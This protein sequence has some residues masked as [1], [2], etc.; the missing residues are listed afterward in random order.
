MQSPGA[1]QQA[2]SYR[3]VYRIPGGLLNDCNYTVTVILTVNTTDKRIV[4]RE[5][6][7]FNVQEEGRPSDYLGNTMG[8][9]RPNLEFMISRLA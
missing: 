5:I 8:I 4:E 7:A 1:D 6:V 9:V 3:T 2:G